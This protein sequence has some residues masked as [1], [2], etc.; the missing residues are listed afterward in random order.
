[1]YVYPSCTYM[2]VYVC[3]RTTINLL[4]MGKALK[5]KQH[6]FAFV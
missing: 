6:V 1:M 2:Y 5:N 3:M 4:H